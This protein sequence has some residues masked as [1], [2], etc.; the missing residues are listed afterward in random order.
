MYSIYLR[1]ISLILKIG[2][3]YVNTQEKE[4]LVIYIRYAYL[5]TCR[6]H[7]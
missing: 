3:Y 1:L 5:K 4:V 2:K 6:E 7:Y